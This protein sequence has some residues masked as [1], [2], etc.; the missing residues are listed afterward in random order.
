MGLLM[1]ELVVTIADFVFRGWCYRR[2]TNHTALRYGIVSRKGCYCRRCVRCLG[3]AYCTLRCHPR[4]HHRRCHFSVPVR[5]L[6]RVHMNLVSWLR[7]AME[8]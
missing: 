1:L 8:I 6:W 7:P 4:S 3:N 5:L 2:D